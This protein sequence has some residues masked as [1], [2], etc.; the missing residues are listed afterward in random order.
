MNATGDL[1][2]LRTF[3]GEEL[4]IPDEQNRFLV[5]IGYGAPNIDYITRQ[6]YK[7]HGATKIDYVLSPRDLTIQFWKKEACSRAEYWANRLAL[8]DLLRPNRGG[9]LELILTIAN[10]VQRAILI[11]PNPGAQFITPQ[12]D[13]NSWSI[14]ETLDFVAFNPIW[15]NPASTV[16]SVARDSTQNLVFPIVFPI[17]F[18]PGGNTYTASIQYD[19]SWQTYPIITITGPYTSLTL[20]NQTTG[21]LITLNTPIVTGESRIIDLTPGSLSVTD[22][23]GNSV[24]GELGD[25]SNLVEFTIEPHPI[26]ANGLN[27]VE[28]DIVDASANTTFEIAYQERFFA[29]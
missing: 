8:H 3:D 11:D 10:G 15:Y 24:F 27:I 26:A 16:T 28:A 7:Q 2:T 22:Q 12:T 21:A 13:D 29:I 4:H 23:D 14:E 18:G 25:D 1:H 19:G 5:Y 9:S 17:E 20:I 6:S